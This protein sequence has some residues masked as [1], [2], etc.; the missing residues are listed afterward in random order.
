M[1]I[2]G[3]EL[4]EAAWAALPAGER[5]VVAVAAGQ[6]GE[7]RPLE[8][9]DQA[10][11]G[12]ACQRFGALVV[13][14]AAGLRAAVE[15]RRP[16]VHG[17]D[18]HGRRQRQQR[19]WPGAGWR[20]TRFA[21][22]EVALLAAHERPVR[23]GHHRFE[24]GLHGDAR[25]DARPGRQRLHAERRHRQPPVDVLDVQPRHARRQPI[26]DDRQVLPGPL[27]TR[28]PRQAAEPPF[29]RHR[30]VA[31][32]HD[33]DVDQLESR[34]EADAGAVG[35]AAVLGAI[36]CIGGGRRAVRA[37]RWRSRRRRPSR[38]PSQIPQPAGRAVPESPV[39]PSVPRSR[40]R[41]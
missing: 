34:T 5:P 21:P 25:I 10:A 32:R 2:G 31:R 30:H 3:D 35:M 33:H 14:D 9:R 37:A 19:H 20:L 15:H 11:V 40:R 7:Q 41:S 24:I 26:V 38:Q 16:G 18:R 23:Q 8:P 17:G 12:S 4:H 1:A 29:A 28:Q 6:I 22:G 39:P 36:G 27:V 13:A